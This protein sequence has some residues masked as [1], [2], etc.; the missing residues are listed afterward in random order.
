MEKVVIVGAGGFGREVIEIFKDQN[1]IK[2]HWDII[3][4]IDETPSLQ[5]KTINNY[6]ILGGLEW[7]EINRKNVGYIVAIGDPKG[8]EKII[9]RLESM[10]VYFVNAIHPTVVMSESVKLGIGVIICAGTILTVNISIGN[11]VI[12]N[13]NSTIGHDVVIDDYCSIMPNVTIS[14]NDKLCTGVYT[15]TGAILIEKISIGEWTTIGAGS[16]VLKNIPK[17]V[18]A[19]GIPANVI[20][21]LEVE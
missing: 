4:F 3:G 8:R 2:K 9:E 15:G 5:G 16:V 20:K 7:I 13:I 10:G 17:N 6:P 14:G 21:T 1:K 12:I 11:H 19:V 18:V